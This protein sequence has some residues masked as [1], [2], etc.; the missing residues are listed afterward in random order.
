MSKAFDMVDH[1]ILL[2]KLDHYG[3]NGTT[4]R[5][6]KSYLTNRLQCVELNQE[7]VEGISKCYSEWKANKCGVP[8][9]STL[10]PLLFLLYINDIDINQPSS[11]LTLFADDTSVSIS[12]IS[13][14]IL[15]SNAQNLMNYISN[16]FKNNKL[17]MNTSKT[18]IM[19]FLAGNCNQ[20]YEIQVLADGQVL[21]SP[22]TVNFLGM[23]IDGGLT[24]ESHINTLCKKLSTALYALHYIS[25]ISEKSALK[26]FYFAKCNS[27][28]LYGIEYWATASKARINRVFILQKRAIRIIAG[29]PFNSSCRNAFKQEKILT[30]Y[31]L[32]ILRIIKFVLNNRTSF[33]SNGDWHNYATSKKNDHRAPKHKLQ[34]AEKGI[35]IIGTRLYNAMPIEIKN[36]SSNKLLLSA[37]KRLLL[38]KAFYSLEEF[39]NQ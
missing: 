13:N 35:G 2:G 7:P 11:K 8:Q 3:F 28:I 38:E 26:M 32:F 22:L 39:Y 23:E 6:L 1:D 30:I 4:G 27:L 24:W 37:L 36:I 20:K 14:T 17:V 25:R 9:G 10:G 16:W 19:T 33:I 5:W 18:N 29:L 15:E 34:F 31:S 12:E 21:P